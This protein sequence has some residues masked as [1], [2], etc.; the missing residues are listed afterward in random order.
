M[1]DQGAYRGRDGIRAYLEDLNKVWG[2][3]LRSHPEEFIEHEDRVVV[4]SRSTATG[5]MRA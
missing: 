3:S 4:M 5:Q 1:L 2:D